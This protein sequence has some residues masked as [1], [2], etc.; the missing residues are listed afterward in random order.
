MQRVVRD[1]DLAQKQVTRI[2][3]WVVDSRTGERDECREAPVPRWRDESVDVVRR[4]DG[5]RDQ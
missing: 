4:V 3:S 1:G 2:S 5:S